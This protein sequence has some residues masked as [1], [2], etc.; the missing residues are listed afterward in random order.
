MKKAEE[1]MNEFMLT[2]KNMRKYQDVKINPI[3]P[4]YD[5]FERAFSEEKKIV[6]TYEQNQEE[7]KEIERQNNKSLT[8]KKEIKVEE[9]PILTIEEID[10]KNKEL[11]EKEK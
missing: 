10:G 9:L 2:W 5:D 1:F 11:L 7:N 6:A 4:N 8:W 3:E